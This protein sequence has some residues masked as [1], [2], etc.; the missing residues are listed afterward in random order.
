MINP[1]HFKNMTDDS[2]SSTYLRRT[3]KQQ[4][5]KQRVEKILS[6]AAAVFDE[7]GYDAATTHQIAAKAGAA[8]GSLYQFFPDKAAIFNAMELRHIERVKA[9]WSQIDIPKIVKLPLID[10]TQTLITATT[11]LFEDPVSRVIFVQFYTAP[12]LFQSI[13]ESMTQEAIA[14]FKS[15]LQQRNPKLAETQAQLLAEACVHSNNAIMLAAFRHPDIDHRQQLID[16]IPKLMCACLQPYVGDRLRDHVMNVMI[17]PHCQCDQLS[18]NGHRRGKQCYR[19]KAC[20]KQFINPAL[21]V[22]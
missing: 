13:D 4:R 20:G 7:V 19:C 12:S 9:F 14:L 1:S 17:C 6:A 11:Q 22:S 18:K 16:Q 15:I 3:P 21:G 10:M 5:G 8:I 2:Y